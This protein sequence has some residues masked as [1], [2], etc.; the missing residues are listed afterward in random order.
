M[1]RRLVGEVLPQHRH[2]Q[3]LRLRCRFLV[4]IVGM[5][6]VFLEQYTRW[7]IK[8]N[9]TTWAAQLLLV[10]SKLLAHSLNANSAQE[11]EK[12]YKKRLQFQYLFQFQSRFIRS[13]ESDFWCHCKLAIL[14][15][16]CQRRSFDVIAIK[17][18][19]RYGIVANKEL[20]TNYTI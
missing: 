11:K 3:R 6:K 14:A 1:C 7:Y 12:K 18:F 15:G 8:R 13:I 17:V 20:Q 4:L 19:N 10:S 16:C 5:K 9:T 2:R